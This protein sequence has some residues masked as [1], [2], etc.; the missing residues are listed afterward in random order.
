MYGDFSRVLDSRLGQ[1]SGVLAQQGRYLLDAEL[2]EQGAL[3]LD[4]IRRLTVDL[5]GPF[6]GP[7]GQDSAFAVKVMVD[8][9]GE[10]CNGIE[11]SPG[12]YYVYGLVCEAPEPGPQLAFEPRPAP[13]V[14]Y[15]RVWEQSVSAI[16][17]PEL[18]DPAL[19][20][21][22]S[23]TARRA[24]V[25]CRPHVGMHLPGEEAD[26]TGLERNALIKE[27][28]VYNKRSRPQMAA[29]A[30]ATTDP[31]ESPTTTPVAGAYRGV[32]NQLYR[33]EIHTP[34]PAQEASFKWSRDNGSAEFAIDALNGGDGSYQATVPSMGRHPG[35]GLEVQDWVEVVD[36]HWSP[37]GD[38]RPM[39]QVQSVSAAAGLVT[40]ASP[41]GAAP[42]AFHAGLHPLLRRW[43]QRP[44]DPA[45]Y[46]G[47]AVE[48]AY[49]HWYEI[50]DGVQIQFH[51]DTVSFERGDY[52]LVP[53]RTST[54]SVIWPTTNG[55]ALARVPHGPPRYLAPLALVHRLDDEK[56]EDLRTTFG[57]LEH[58]PDPPAPPATV[59][60]N[61]VTVTTIGPRIN[62]FRLRPVGRFQPGHSFDIPEGPTAIGRGPGEDIR[63][64]RPIVS[65]QHLRVS[66][67]DGRIVVEDRNSANGTFVN[68]TRI[69]AP[70][71]LHVG[72]VIGLGGPE[73]VLLEVE[74]APDGGT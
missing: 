22:V 64:D 31:E 17:A 42:L 10:K 62:R 49:G 47:I 37:F 67:V 69:Q 51:P 29:R 20:L 40:L 8:Q 63:L 36:D 41:A 9:S 50:E 59:I 28:D 54:S 55:Q 18:L 60:A 14:V 16:Q 11:L 43:D 52:W 19:A 2:N 15:L 24:Q 6:A 44:G 5:V 71:E 73:D 70:V 32:E 74:P 35:G 13:F 23:D 56:P 38:P 39:L 25:R 57:P 12:H 48:Q 7:A 27:F 61:T 72:D 30:Y 34:G 46:D 1:F 33:V 53:A 3:L 68:G 45:S 4:Y 66:V 21:Q 65:R 26:L 58:E